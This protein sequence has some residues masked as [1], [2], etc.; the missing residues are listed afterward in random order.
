M[1]RENLAM[2]RPGTQ[3]SA[4]GL[5]LSW[6]LGGERD[7][8]HFPPE[9]RSE[10]ILQRIAR[11]SIEEVDDQPT[12]PAETDDRVYRLLTGD[13]A[14]RHKA[15]PAGPVIRYVY[16]R[17][18]GTTANATVNQAGETEEFVDGQKRAVEFAE[19]QRQVEI[20]RQIAAETKAASK[21]AKE[22]PEPSRE[23]RVAA[24][25]Q[26]AETDKIAFREE[27]RHEEFAR[28]GEES[29]PRDKQTV[30][31]RTVQTKRQ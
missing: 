27:Q 12:T 14:R 28:R 17:D 7:V 4:D 8:V 18:D 3:F 19:E 15:E 2:R 10:R 30:V 21:P 26:Q 1:S 5:A 20:D 13:E 6:P 11:G 22:S 31:T 29:T 16:R 23:E 9:K 25:Q 24:H